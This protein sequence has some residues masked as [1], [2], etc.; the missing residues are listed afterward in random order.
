MKPIPLSEPYRNRRRKALAW[1]A[2]FLHA[3]IIFNLYEFDQMTP[4]IIK[5]QS[6]SFCPRP[7]PTPRGTR[8]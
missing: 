8:T 3:V 6:D 1:I 5:V 2:V 7:Q 4:R